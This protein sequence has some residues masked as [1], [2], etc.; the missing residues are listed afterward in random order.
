MIKR[1]IN[2]EMVEEIT[3]SYDPIRSKYV[4]NICMVSGAKAYISFTDKDAAE[5]EYKRFGGTFEHIEIFE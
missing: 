3:L 1:L 5:E 2:I 4:V